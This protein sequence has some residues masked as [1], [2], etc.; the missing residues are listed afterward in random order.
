MREVA[1][2]GVGM[3]KFGE[4]WD[5]SLR[6]LI[7][8][9]GLMAISDAGITSNDI[10]AVYGGC[11]SAGQFISQE[12][13]AALIADF[14]G[15]A[16]RYIP[17]TRVEAACAS[18]GVALRQ[19]YIAV[20]SGM[21]DV[22][23]IGGVEKMTDV[24]ESVA[25]EALATASDQEWEAFLGL[26]FPALYALIARKHMNDYGTK[27]EHLA[28]VA[29][30]NHKNACLNPNAQFK[31]EITIEQVLNAQYVAEPLTVLDCSPITDGAAA[32]VLCSME[33]AKSLS[34]KSVKIIGSGQASDCLALHARKDI[35]TL[36]ASVHAARRAY[37]Q[38]GIGPK[39]INVAEVH[40][41]FTIAEIIAIEDLGFV[42]KG[43]GGKTVEQGLTSLDSEKP[44]NT[45]GGLKACGN[46]LGA[47]GIAQAV[48][49]VTQLRGNA[50]KRQV[51]NAKIGLTHNVGGSG[52]TA[53][54]HIFEVI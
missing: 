10:D 12:H 25:T 42:K 22:V 28:S 23:V 5:K 44:V 43:D 47:T 54:V 18:G 6:D 20:A 2:I 46:P 16:S 45:S 48:E 34:E 21:H 17:A 19:G 35:C 11:M 37:K 26:T 49:I 50:G 27:R 53:V 15:L 13:I 32:L 33:K 8:E 14:A 24:S 29:V 7:V 52:A 30:K 39:N 41:C 4:L 3:T 38:A 51:K 36:E 1:V 40:D 9:A 31:R